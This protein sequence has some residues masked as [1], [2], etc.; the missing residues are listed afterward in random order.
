MGKHNKSSEEFI[1]I[2]ARFLEWSERPSAYRDLR[3]CWA[4]HGLG[5]LWNMFV[6]SGA[7][8]WAA[9]I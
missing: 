8:N 4:P 2:I 1:A 3:K 6:F 9:A 5:M 7:I